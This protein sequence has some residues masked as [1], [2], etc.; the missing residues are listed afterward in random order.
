MNWCGGAAELPD[1]VSFLRGLAG[2][3]P[4]GRDPFHYFLRIVGKTNFRMRRDPGVDRPV[5]RGTGTSKYS[6]N[7]AK[8]IRQHIAV[9]QV[10]FSIERPYA[11]E[12]MTN[13]FIVP[14]LTST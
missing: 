10:S 5:H 7:T 9:T 11:A 12:P 13:Q 14:A 6:D 1:S 4:H 3:L 8:W 2:S